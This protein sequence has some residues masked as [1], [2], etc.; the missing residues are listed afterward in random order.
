LVKT[1]D[2]ADDEAVKVEA[3]DDLGAGR[4]NAITGS[5]FWFL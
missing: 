4:L 3:L 2:L 1:T 5:I